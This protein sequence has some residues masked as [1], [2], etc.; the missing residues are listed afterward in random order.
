MN[1][2]RSQGGFTLLE[3]MIS[4]A[5]L[6]MALTM[7]LSATA[8]NVELAN[9]ARVL[10][11]VTNLTRGKM[12]DLEEQLLQEGFQ[13]TNQELDGDFSDEGHK[14][15]EWEA[16]VE[17]I[18]L[19]GLAD[20]Q[21]A[22]DSVAGGDG[23]GGSP[24]GGLIPGIPG[25]GGG[26]GGEA[27][28]TSAAGAAALTSQFE[29]VATIL[30]QAMRKVTL[31]VKWQVGDSAEEMTVVAYFTDP[32]AVDL[33]VGGLGAVGGGDNNNNNNGNNNNT[34]NANPTGR[35]N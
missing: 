8:S 6:A 7:L 20:A 28:N 11:T 26:G 18:E 5:I 1:R 35:S 9:R 19:P 3:V 33:A 15:I 14:E 32:T 22:A 29:T 23:G 13:E 27:G 25:G 34:N 4:L 21:N 10:G 12:F 31:T 16:T 17:K 24:L 30:E 2:R